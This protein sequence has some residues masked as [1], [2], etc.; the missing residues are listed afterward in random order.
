[1]NHN[2]S[3]STLRFDE[4]GIT[5]KPIVIEDDVWIGANAVI[6]PGVKIGRHSVVA[7]GAV[8][9]KDVPSGTLV[10]GVPAT[11]KKTLI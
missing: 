10:A 7:A 5:T 3:D 1:M 6:L 11:V 9:N 2:I 8:V 4:Q